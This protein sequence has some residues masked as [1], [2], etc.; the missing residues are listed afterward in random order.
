MAEKAIGDI[1][2]Y[3]PPRDETTVVYPDPRGETVIPRAATL[4]EPAYPAFVEPDYSPP[5]PLLDE[6]VVLDEPEV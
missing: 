3:P 2:Y 5:V 6:P 4:D 1:T